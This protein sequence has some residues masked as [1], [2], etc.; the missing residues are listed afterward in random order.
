MQ[1]EKSRLVCAI[2]RKVVLVGELQAEWKLWKP[3]GKNS[4]EDKGYRSVTEDIS[5]KYLE[6]GVNFFKE[7]F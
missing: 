3:E 2:A 4:K 6:R 7:N 5:I 1:A